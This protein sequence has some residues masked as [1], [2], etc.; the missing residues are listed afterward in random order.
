MKWT[1]AVMCPTACAFM[2]HDNHDHRLVI[3]RTQITLDIW[4]LVDEILFLSLQVNATMKEPSR[5]LYVTW[6]A[7]E[8]LCL[9]TKNLLLYGVC[10]ASRWLLRSDFG[11]LFA[12]RCRESSRREPKCHQNSCQSQKCL[13]RN[14]SWGD[15]TAFSIINDIGNID[16][17]FVRVHAY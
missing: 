7:F 10:K 5:I 16:P 17:E 3:P 12:K 11:I 6:G 13:S 9:K 2:A 4:N 14:I 1:S 8:N 15:A